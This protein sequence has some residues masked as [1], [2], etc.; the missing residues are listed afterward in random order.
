M[1]AAEFATLHTLAT[2]LNHNTWL[3]AH[4]SCSLLSVAVQAYAEYGMYAKKHA[5]ASTV[6]HLCNHA[7]ERLT[8]VG[9]ACFCMLFQAAHAYESKQGR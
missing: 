8:R 7:D 5:M 9:Q 2:H 3:T 4:R 6:S 1:L